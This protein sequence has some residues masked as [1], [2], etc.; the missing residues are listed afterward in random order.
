MYF[1]LFLFKDKAVQLDHPDLH[2]WQAGAGAQ[3]DGWATYNKRS[4]QRSGVTGP[5][6][7]ALVAE[8]AGALQSRVGTD[9][10]YVLP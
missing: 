6:Q 10:R 2:L 7:P 1:V 9:Y 5:P 3:H 8:G 4:M